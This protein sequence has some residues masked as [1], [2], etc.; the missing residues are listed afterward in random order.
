[1]NDSTKQA[2]MCPSIRRLAAP[3]VRDAAGNASA[4]RN[5]ASQRRT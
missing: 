3:L 1:V 2:Q 5:T 4:W